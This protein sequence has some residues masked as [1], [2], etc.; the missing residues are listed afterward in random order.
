MKRVLNKVCVNREN[1]E[2]KPRGTERFVIRLS[3]AL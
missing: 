1:I 3:F 2:L